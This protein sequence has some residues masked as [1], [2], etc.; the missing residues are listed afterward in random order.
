MWD[1]KPISSVAA[2]ALLAVCAAACGPR[3]L[4]V[5]EPCVDGSSATCT[6]LGDGA[7]PGDATVSDSAHE[8]DQ[9]SMTLRQGL[10]GLWH[11]D[12][13]MGSLVASDSSGNMNT[14]TLVGLNP[15]TVWTDGQLAGGLETNAAG[16]ATVPRSATIDS[17]VEQVTLAAWVYR[18]GTI[19]DFGTAA[20]RQIGTGLT[21]HY[22]LSLDSDGRPTAFINRGVPSDFYRMLSAPNPVTAKTWTHLAVTYDGA[23]A[24]LYVDGTQVHAL[25][26]SGTFGP[27]TTPL[28]LG[29]NG[30]YQEVTERFPGRVDEIVLY[31]RALTAAEVGQLAAGVLF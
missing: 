5:I 8:S 28:I 18:D 15:S 20:S 10:V 2:V 19:V 27:D 25:P 13:G 24:R 9:S 31:N 29:G 4:V 26:I 12:D 23:N 22:H 7:V 1:Y 16:Y 11:F 17:I 14:G 30:N 3:T 21:Q 6:N